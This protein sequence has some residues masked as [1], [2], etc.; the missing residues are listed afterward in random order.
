MM[1]IALPK[2]GQDPAPAMG[3]TAC[4]TVAQWLAEAL[5]TIRERYH[6]VDQLRPRPR[7]RP[8]NATD[9]AA[10]LIARRA[11]LDQ[12]AAAHERLTTVEFPRALAEAQAGPT[13]S[14]LRQVA[15][16]LVELAQAAC[17]WERSLAGVELH[18]T[19]AQPH[20]RLRWSTELWL[21]DVELLAA[22]MASP[23]NAPPAAS[24]ELDNNPP[25]GWGSGSSIPRFSRR[26]RRTGIVTAPPLTDRSASSRRT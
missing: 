22:T 19:F 14:P 18:L 2:D 10:F 7:G 5:A 24:G 15:A 21:R 20:Q 6:E 25:R 16:E 23:E 13:A 1:Q 8:L 3:P 17:D 4:Q 11:E 12:L 9:S 26:V